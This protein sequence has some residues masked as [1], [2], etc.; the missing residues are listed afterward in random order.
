M[1]PTAWMS[2]GYFFLMNCSGPSSHPALSGTALYT[3][4]SLLVAGSSTTETSG[5]PGLAFRTVPPKLS[6]REKFPTMAKSL[7]TAAWVACLLVA[8]VNWS[9]ESVMTSFRPL[10]PPVEST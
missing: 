6:S 4:C 2:F 7:L 5:I 1:A 9:S 3:L 8:P 10:M